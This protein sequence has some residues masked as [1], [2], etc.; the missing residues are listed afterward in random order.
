MFFSRTQHNSVAKQT[1]IVFR[2]R[3]CRISLTNYFFICRK[4]WLRHTWGI[5]RGDFTSNYVVRCTRAR[6]WHFEAFIR[7]KPLRPSWGYYF[8]WETRFWAP[9]RTTDWR[10]GKHHCKSALRSCLIAEN[11]VALNACSFKERYVLTIVALVLVY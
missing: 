7:S 10:R 4:L 9:C 8:R 6:S 11:E 1:I 3:T 2:Y 5:S